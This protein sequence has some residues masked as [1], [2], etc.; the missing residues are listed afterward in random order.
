MKSGIVFVDEFRFE[1][2]FRRGGRFLS[3]DHD[4]PVRQSKDFLLNAAFRSPANLLIKINSFSRAAA[5]AH[6]IL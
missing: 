3:D 1:K 2:Q 4:V 5:I 6:T